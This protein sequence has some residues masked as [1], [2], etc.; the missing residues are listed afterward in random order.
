MNREAWLTEL[1]AQV[2]PLFK[3]FV[4]KPYRV[5]CGWPCKGALTRRARRIGECHALESSKGGVHEIFVS[6]LIDTSA[7]VAGVV[8]HELAHVVAGIPAAH[9]SKFVT[10]CRSVGLTSGK[11]TSVMPGPVLAEQLQKIITKLGNYPHTALVPRASVVSKPATSTGLACPA[12]G[13]RI[14]ISLRWLDEAGA[15][16]CACGTLMEQVRK[17]E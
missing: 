2:V 12:C 4:L 1:A 14:S 16:T 7:E 8:C 11:P 6:P 9:G 13:C 3:G 5:T 15:P 10:V 17:D